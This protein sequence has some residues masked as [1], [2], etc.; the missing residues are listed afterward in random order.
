MDCESITKTEPLKNCS[1]CNDPIP[2]ADKKKASRI[3]RRCRNDIAKDYRAA[4]P[5]RIVETNR[6]YWLNKLPNDVTSRKNTRRFPKSEVPTFFV[7]KCHQLRTNA[8]KR[9]IS[10]DLTPSD[11]FHLFEN[12]GETCPYCDGTFD[13]ISI[14][15]KDNDLGYSLDNCIC[16]CPSC[17]SL[18]WMAN[19]IQLRNIYL[20][21]FGDVRPSEM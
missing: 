6:R 2:L 4:H 19:K 14:D 5:E 13:R 11:V 9:E 1:K 17:N 16:V 15:R 10:F 18:K 3:C 20:H 21:L 7:T 8:E 12:K